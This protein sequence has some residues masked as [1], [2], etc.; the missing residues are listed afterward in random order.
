MPWGEIIPKP[1]EF[2]ISIDPIIKKW[3]DV[4]FHY[5]YETVMGRDEAAKKYDYKGVEEKLEI[6][7][8]VVVPQDVALG[9][10]AK[11]EVIYTVLMP[12]ERQKVRITEIRTLVHGNETIELARREVERAQGS[13]QSTMEFTVP[14]GIP[15]GDYTLITTIT[16][17]KQTKFSNA[18]MKII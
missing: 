3:L 15:K 5:Y 16:D 17:S 4:V 6:D 14:E 12:N 8:S 2:P 9:K 10:T 18:P 11:A 1:P 7:R 13:H